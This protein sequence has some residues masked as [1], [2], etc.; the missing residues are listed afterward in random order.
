MLIVLILP[1]CVIAKKR[2]TIAYNTLIINTK[3]PKVDQ[4]QTLIRQDT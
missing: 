3:L 4:L 2:K 1:K